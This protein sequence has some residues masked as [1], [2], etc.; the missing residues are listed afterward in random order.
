MKEYH[1]K[2]QS[3]SLS[4]EVLTKLSITKFITIIIII[5]IIHTY[6]SIVFCHKSEEQRLKIT[7]NAY[8]V[9]KILTKILIIQNYFRKLSLLNNKLVRSFIITKIGSSRNLGRSCNMWGRGGGGLEVHM[10][11]MPPR[12]YKVSFFPYFGPSGRLLMEGIRAF[13]IPFFVTCNEKRHI[14]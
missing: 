13:K 2:N 4:A 3:I 1:L 9:P 12:V 7:K 11:L 5:I 14:Q 10:N 6:I 8:N